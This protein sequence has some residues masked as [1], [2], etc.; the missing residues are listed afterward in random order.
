MRDLDLKV[1]QSFAR[2]TGGARCNADRGEHDVR[3]ACNMSSPWVALSTEPRDDR[4]GSTIERSGQHR[5]D[6]KCA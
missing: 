6:R 5:H 2:A 1:A 4:F 3:K